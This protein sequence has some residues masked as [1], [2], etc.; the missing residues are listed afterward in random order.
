MSARSHAV[1]ERA[2]SA[3]A[4][5]PRAASVAC[6]R[7]A[8][9]PAGR[10]SRGPAA[11]RCS[12][13]RPWCRAGRRPRP[14]R[15][16]APR[17]GSARPAAVGGRCCSAATNASSTLSRA[18]TAAGGVGRRQGQGVRGSARA[19]PP[20]QRGS[21]RSSGRGTARGRSAAA[22]APLPSARQAAL[23]AIRYSQVRSEPRPSNRGRPAPRAQQR[24]LQR[25]L[26]VV[27]ASRA[28]GSSARAAR[29]GAPRPAGRTRPLVPRAPPRAA[30]A[31]PAVGSIRL[32]GPD[33]VLEHQ[34]ADGEQQ[35][36][37]RDHDRPDVEE[38]QRDGQQRRPTPA[39]AIGQ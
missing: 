19:M 9:R 1:D 6:W 7:G 18:R 36:D 11:A 17:A 10:P 35:D 12:P 27:H 2:T 32:V 3:P 33:V 39:S 24:L 5:S 22:A 25:V 14:P 34:P 38:R 16:P 8:G 15:T 21:P 31:R 4:G 20:R 37:H 23:V 30:P 29:G 28:S 26:G 13:R